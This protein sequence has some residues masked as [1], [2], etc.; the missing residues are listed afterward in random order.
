MSTFNERK[1]NYLWKKEVDYR[2]GEWYELQ[3]GKQI[4]NF[5]GIVDDDKTTLIRHNRYSVIDWTVTKKNIIFNEET[6]KKTIE[7]ETTS[8]E[9]KTRTCKKDTYETTMYPINKFRK[10]IDNLNKNKVQKTYCVFIFT[11]CI[12]YYEI[13]KDSEKEITIAD[14]GRSDRGFRESSTYAYIPI[15]KLKIIETFKC[16]PPSVDVLPY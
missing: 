6:K 14:G 13:T 5:F 15:D 11:D 8:I 10:Q 7:K 3:Y 12:A 4:L 9:L 16:H 2:I 1:E